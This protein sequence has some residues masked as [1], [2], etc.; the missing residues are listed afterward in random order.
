MN[1]QELRHVDVSHARLAY[2][3][4]GSGPPLVLV[5]GYPV[6]GETWRK[7]VP[8]LAA[9]FT[10]YAPDLPGLGATEWTDATDFSFPGQAATL[11]RWIDDVGLDGYDLVAHDT[12]G[13]IARCLADG[14]AARVRRLVLINTEMPGHRPPWI[15]L[16]RHLAALPGAALNFGALLR[17]RWFR[18]SS[19]GLGGCFT[20]RDLLDGDFHARFIAPL[21]ASRR[22]M[23]GSLRY[24]RGIGWDVVDGMR[25]VHARLLM[26]T[27]LVWGAEDPTFP[28]A[29]GRA[30]AGQFPGGAAFVSIPRAALL[31]HEEQPEAVLRALID[32]LAAD[33]PAAAGRL[34]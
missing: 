19:M 10:C 6:H 31:P 17:Q 16:Y 5:H 23:E 20:D 2:R 3:V 4:A 1:D 14:D 18:R 7:V 8:G 11:R 13:T 25:A 12:G 9:R 26:P 32:F 27:A 28:A 21:L 33:R 29:L 34:H 30:M 22:R 24:L 15:P